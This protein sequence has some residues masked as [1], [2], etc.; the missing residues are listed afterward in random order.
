M[1][2]ILVAISATAALFTTAL[3]TTKI[4]AEPP[5]SGDGFGSIP[6]GQNDPALLAEP[7]DPDWGPRIENLLYSKIADSG[8]SLASLSI[9][10]RTTGWTYAGG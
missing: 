2:T 3:F 7:K 6:Q 5:S 4:F 1:R 10:C 9:D 8:H